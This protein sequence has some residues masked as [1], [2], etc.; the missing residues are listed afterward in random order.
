MNDTHTI[1]LVEDNPNDVLFVGLP[2]K[3]LGL[4]HRLIVVADG[5]EAQQYLQG[6]RQYS[7]RSRFPWPS[8]ILLDLDMPRM[9]GFQ[10]LEWLRQQPSLCHLPVIVLTTSTYSPD[11]TRAYQVGANSF[12]VKPLDFINFRSLLRTLEAFWLRQSQVPQVDRPVPRR[13]A[14][15]RRSRSSRRQ[16]RRPADGCAA[17]STPRLPIQWRVQR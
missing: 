14:Q 13:G 3:R 1:L 17:R 12:L 2:F 8:L 9:D 5:I 4:K 15:R 11:V 7:D 16:A 6:D 10:L